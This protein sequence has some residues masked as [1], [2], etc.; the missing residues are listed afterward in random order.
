M[1]IAFHHIA[2]ETADL[3]R[4]LG[5][6]QRVLGFG[7]ERSMTLPG[8]WIVFLRLG[9]ARVELVYAEDEPSEREWGSTN[10]H[11][12]FEVDSIDALLERLAAYHIPI[13]EGP[14]EL[15]NGWRSLFIEG[16]D[17]EKIE[18]LALGS[19]ETGRIKF[20]HGEIEDVGK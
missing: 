11:I 20:K 12:A 15:D 1:R 13:E 14:I 16:P 8:E 5:F 9:D 2:I 7:V 3:G 19:L 17:M 10:V 4:S 18:F 6:Y